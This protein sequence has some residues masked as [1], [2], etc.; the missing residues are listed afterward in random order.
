[1]SFNNIIGST[2][3]NAQIVLPATP[4]VSYVISNILGSYSSS[5][6][7]G[8][9]TV[10]VVFGSTKIF[11]MDLASIN[12]NFS[13]LEQSSPGDAVTVTLSGIALIVAKLNVQYSSF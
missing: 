9:G 2:G 5:I 1:M 3:A 13:I 8:A 4:G 10:S 12:F 7:I 6:T 11:E